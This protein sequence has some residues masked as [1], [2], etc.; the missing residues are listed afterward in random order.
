MIKKLL[1]KLNYYKLS[2]LQPYGHCGCCGKSI[3]TVFVKN[4]SW[5]ICDNCKIRN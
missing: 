2:Q 3:N 5:G 4:Y 1:N